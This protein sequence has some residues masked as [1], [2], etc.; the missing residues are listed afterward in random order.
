MLL[1]VDL[2]DLNM[3]NAN[4]L[5]A[6]EMPAPEFNFDDSLLADSLLSVGREEPKV[7]EGENVNHFGMFDGQNDFCGENMEHAFDSQKYFDS[8]LGS[9]FDKDSHLDGEKESVNLRATSNL[10][11]GKSFQGESSSDLQVKGDLIV[12]KTNSASS[13]VSS[14][15]FEE[16]PKTATS[17]TN[18]LLT[19]NEVSTVRNLF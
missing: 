17:N 5:F 9:P 4:S 13:D 7:G 14:K 8:I 1:T 11:D 6:C 12:T 15:S 16:A 10:Q 3:E 18:S 19:S 2:I